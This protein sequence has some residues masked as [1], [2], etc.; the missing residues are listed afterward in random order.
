[1]AIF[2]PGTVL[3]HVF[4]LLFNFQ[5]HH[6]NTV[7]CRSQL[8]PV[9]THIEIL[10]KMYCTN[11][12]QKPGWIY[13]ISIEPSLWLNYDIIEL[14]EWRDDLMLS[15]SRVSRQNKGW[16]FRE[17]RPPGAQTRVCWLTDVLAP[18][19]SAHKG[20][21]YPDPFGKGRCRT[22]RKGRG[23][24]AATHFLCYLSDCFFSPMPAISPAA[25][26]H[27]S[28]T[29]AL[30]QK[31]KPELETWQEQTLPKTKTAQ[32]RNFRAEA[33]KWNPICFL[34]RLTNFGI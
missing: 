33:K 27:G 31:H 14:L 26:Q 23:I 20:R 34:H 25:G 2:T 8:A 6:L 1:M 16:H 11:R 22:G 4:L 18:F 32:F 24:W 17:S 12:C 9:H 29:L 13:C 7:T 19:R 15:N 21:K 3:A 5:P 30:A 10:L 28:R